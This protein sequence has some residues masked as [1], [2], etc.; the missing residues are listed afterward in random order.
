MGSTGEDTISSDGDKPY[1]IAF[2]DGGDELRQEGQKG[3]NGR[4]DGCCNL[5]DGR[6]AIRLFARGG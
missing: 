4:V 5:E 2:D 3:D 1:M 6:I